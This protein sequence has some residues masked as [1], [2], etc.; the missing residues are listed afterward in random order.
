VVGGYRAAFA[1]AEDYDLWLRLSEHFH[2]AN[3]KEVVVK[4]RIHPQ[5]ESVSRRKQQTFCVVAA[6]ASAAFRK[7]GSPDLLDSEKAITPELLAR[8]GVSEAEVQTSLFS[9]CR[10]WI[11]NMSAAKEQSVALQIAAEVLQSDWKY[12][13]RRDLASLQL[14]AA[15][16]YWRQKQFPKSFAVA[17]Q[18][19]RELPALAKYFGQ[20]LLRRIERA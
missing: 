13:K 2:C 5:Q 4:Y 12:V 10:D 1:P 17:C 18:V 19:V 11:R 7:N 3:L 9:N 15:R 16:L 8:L 14:M 6:R 20:A